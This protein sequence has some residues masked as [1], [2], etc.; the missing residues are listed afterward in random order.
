METVS[1]PLDFWGGKLAVT[2]PMPMEGRPGVLTRYRQHRPKRCGLRPGGT[3]H[4]MGGGNG[5]PRDLMAGCRRAIKQPDVGVV[6][7]RLSTTVVDAPEEVWLPC[8]CA[9]QEWSSF[10]VVGCPGGGFYA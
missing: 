3:T 7:V 6:G 10:G 2:R 8:Q 9:L 5:L 1:G 4:Q